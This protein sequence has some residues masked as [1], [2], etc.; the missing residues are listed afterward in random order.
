[1]IKEFEPFEVQGASYNFIV[2]NTVMNKNQAE[3]VERTPFPLVGSLTKLEEYLYV[4][5]HM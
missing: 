1:M 3:I 5:L 4:V 2:I